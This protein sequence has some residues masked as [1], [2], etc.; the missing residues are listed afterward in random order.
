MQPNPFFVSVQTKPRPF[1]DA[2][3][4]TLA[5]APHLDRLRV[6]CFGSNDIS[7][8]GLDALASADWAPSLNRLELT[9]THITRRELRA[10][11]SPAFGNLRWLDLGSGKMTYEEIPHL[12]AI[13]WL[14][15]LTHLILR[16][17]EIGYEG[18]RL[19]AS[20]PLDAIEFLDVTKNK[21]A[22]PECELLR[23]RFG[24]RVRLRN[25]CDE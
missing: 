5:R 16:K 2:S 8:V 13:P 17:N 21:I 6:L 3:A 12:L 19:L 18:A 25:S 15:H 24:D 20:A 7:D 4:K 10:L 1:G 11:S 23:E 9:D 22:E 14:P